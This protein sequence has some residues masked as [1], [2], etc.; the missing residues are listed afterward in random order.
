MSAPRTPISGLRRWLKQNPQPSCIRVDEKHTMR[1]PTHASRWSETEKSIIAG[2]Y[3]KLEAMGPNGELLRALNLDTGNDSDEKPVQKEDW[4]DSE[5]AQLA[6]VITAACDRA[7]SR[8]EN[9]YRLAFDKLSEQYTSLSS[10][11]EEALQRCARLEMQLLKLQYD[12][13]AE[14]VGETNAADAAMQA[15]VAVAAQRVLGS[16][17]EAPVKN[18]KAKQ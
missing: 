5:E 7:A 13:T 6:Q 16:G 15:F 9:A 2:G 14:P 4:P 17:Q 10:R 18:G 8:H 11:H 3:T 12:L 1:V